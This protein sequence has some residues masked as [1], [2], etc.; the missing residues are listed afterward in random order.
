MFIHEN[1]LRRDIS[2]MLLIYEDQQI[3]INIPQMSV[4]WP[5]FGGWGLNLTCAED[6][7][8][9]NENE[10][11]LYIWNHHLQAIYLI[12]LINADIRCPSIW[13]VQW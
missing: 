7:Q 9:A 2:F 5:S 3:I 4:T 1:N 13:G 8:Y 10:N 12:H 6:K 11:S